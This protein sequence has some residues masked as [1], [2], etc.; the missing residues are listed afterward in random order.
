MPQAA[1]EIS[2]ATENP[3]VEENMGV[4]RGLAGDRRTEK[5]VRMGVWVSSACLLYPYLK[6]QE[7]PPTNKPK[8]PACLPAFCIKGNSCPSGTWRSLED[9]RGTSNK[10]EMCPGKALI[11]SRSSPERPRG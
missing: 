8:T 5:C 11:Y 7:M 2:S 6:V 3:R 1:L 9:I 10:E 4:V